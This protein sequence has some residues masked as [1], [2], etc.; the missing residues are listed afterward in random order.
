MDLYTLNLKKFH[1]HY[2][3]YLLFCGIL[4]YFLLPSFPEISPLVFYVGC[5]TSFFLQI[6]AMELRF[7][8]RFHP[9]L[10]EMGFPLFTVVFFFWINLGVLAALIF[11]EFPFEAIIGFLIAYFLH[12]LFLVFASYF[13]GK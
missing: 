8:P 10:G 13:S 1:L 11:L 3:T 7:L 5:G 9:K 4:S 12:L 6:G 2:F